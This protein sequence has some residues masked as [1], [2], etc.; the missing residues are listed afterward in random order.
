M[1]QPA[2]VSTSAPVSNFDAGRPGASTP[3][4]QEP[5][6]SLSERLAAVN[7]SAA[8]RAEGPSGAPVRI[9]S[10]LTPVSENRS[11]AEGPALSVSRSGTAPAPSVSA[12]PQAPVEP[13][14]D[15][16]FD[17]GFATSPPQ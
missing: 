15:F 13:A 10:S 17:I 4:K 14:G 16:H 1:Y 2:P 8:P 12:A 3:I 11:F 5:L 7:P 6:S 9:P